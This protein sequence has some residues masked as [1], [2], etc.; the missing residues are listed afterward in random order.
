[1]GLWIDLGIVLGAISVCLNIILAFLVL[2]KSKVKKTQNYDVTA[3]LRD[4]TSPGRAMVK[5]EYV[6]QNDFFLRSPRDRA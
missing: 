5:I 2:R 6:D 4:L 1:M 3:L